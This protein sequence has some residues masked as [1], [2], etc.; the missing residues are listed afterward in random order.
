MLKSTQEDSVRM[1]LVLAVEDLL[2]KLF[3]WAN[4]VAKYS[5]VIVGVDPDFLWPSVEEEGFYRLF[6]FQPR[7]TH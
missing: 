1:F 3:A 6:L 7:K 5:G 4:R 2:P